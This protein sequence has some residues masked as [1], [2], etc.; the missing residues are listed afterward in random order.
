MYVIISSVVDPLKCFATTF[1]LLSDNS[2]PYIS[3]IIESPTIAI[4]IWSFLGFGFFLLYLKFTF[5]SVEILVL[6]SVLLLF[7]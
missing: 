7:E 5:F 4:T 1:S 3:L 2:H 6:F